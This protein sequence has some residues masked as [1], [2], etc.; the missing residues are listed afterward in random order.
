MP[1]VAFEATPPTFSPPPPNPARAAQSSELAQSSPFQ[2]LLDGGGQAAPEP[3]PQSQSQPQSQPQPAS[4]DTSINTTQTDS[5]LTKGQTTDGDATP[6]A[7]TDTPAINSGT[8]IRTADAGNLIPQDA[9]TTGCK[10]VNTGKAK[11][12]AK[13]CEKTSAGDDAKPAG[14]GKTTA[15]PTP[16]DPAA[17]LAVNPIPTA[18]PAAAVAAAVTVAAT[19]D[20]TPQTVSAAVLQAAPAATGLPAIAAAF[21]PKIKQ[22]NLVAQAD[23]GKP[24]DDSK[25]STKTALTLQ[26]NGKLQ[27]AT[28]DAE[29]QIVSQPHDESPTNNHHATT[30]DAQPANAA[31]VP[32]A[33]PKVAAEAGQQQAA[34]TVAPQ[35]TAQYAATPAAPAGPAP[36]A[37]QALAVPLTGVA[38]EIVGR[39][40]DGKNHFE[41]R[42]DPP[43]LGRIEVRLAVDRDGNTTTRLIADRSDTLNLLRSNSSG[44]ERALQDAGLKTADNSLQFS[45]RDQSMGR[46]QN[47]NPTPGA[48]QIVV[49]DDALA[50]PELSPRNYPRLAGLGGGVDIRV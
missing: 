26:A 42:L 4:N 40:L 11:A 33:A 2:S 34:L 46:D 16:A 14:G 5:H 41:I 31:D 22:A 17:V 48:A 8:T 23:T 1:S 15:S 29:K 50:A 21:T 3:P 43:E 49:K 45:L 12:D 25:S 6:T 35:D 44:L 38:V 36:L 10:T 32:I 47:N 37:A 30:A 9:T 19:S 20:A 7:N 39:A 18:V 27:P 28:A 24:A 13:I